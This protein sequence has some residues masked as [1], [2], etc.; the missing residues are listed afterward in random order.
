MSNSQGDEEQDASTIYIPF[1]TFGQAFNRGEN[2][3]WMA[4][5]ALMV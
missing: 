2:V 4:I 5:T 3:G 1:T